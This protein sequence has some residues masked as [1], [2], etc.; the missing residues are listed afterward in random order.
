MGCIFCD[1]VS[2]KIPAKK[3]YEDDQVLA[4]DDIEPQAPVH[5]VIIPKKHIEGIVHVK[6]AD[7]KELSGLFNA[8]NDVARKKK[9]DSGGFRVIVNHGR[10]AGQAVGHLHFHVMGGR[11]MEW[12][13]G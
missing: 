7:S 5:V 6:D 4:F 2:G 9:I 13:P 11:V 1:I 12:P 8:V 3:V 10:D